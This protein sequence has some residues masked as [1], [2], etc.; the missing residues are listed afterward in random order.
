MRIRLIVVIIVILFVVVAVTFAYPYTTFKTPEVVN[1]QS[2][3]SKSSTILNPVFYLSMEIRNPNPY[4]VALTAT[5]MT[6]SFVDGVSITLQPAYVPVEFN[7]NGI[8]YTAYVGSLSPS[9]ILQLYL[10]PPS[11][12]TVTWQATYVAPLG[13]RT[14]TCV[15]TV[16]IQTNQVTYTCTG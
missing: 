9:Q 11:S 5:S 14:I 13:S 16:F 7:P 6:I 12:Y 3:L 4:P 1:M 8:N 15:W 2:G 10:S